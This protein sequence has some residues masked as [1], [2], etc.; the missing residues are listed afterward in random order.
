MVW[1]EIGKKTH[2]CLANTTASEVISDKP[3]ACDQDQKQEAGRE[4]L[5]LGQL[6]AQVLTEI[7]DVIYMHVN[8]SRRSMEEMFSH[9]RHAQLMYRM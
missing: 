6:F 4:Q 9:D 1:P 5:I 8:S 7:T 3:K 2:I